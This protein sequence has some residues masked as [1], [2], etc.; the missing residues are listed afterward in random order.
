MSKNLVSGG[1]TRI[2]IRIDNDV[3]D[4]FKKDATG[5]VG[6][7]YQTLINRALREYIYNRGQFDETLL[8]QIIR[9]ELAESRK[10]LA[11]FK[12]NTTI[13]R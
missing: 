3:L 2:T 10:G 11:T 12:T 9:E 6:E 8:R 5:E 7:N 1:K 13:S 4:W